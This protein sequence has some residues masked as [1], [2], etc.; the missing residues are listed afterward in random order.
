MPSLPNI[1][2]AA[3]TQATVQALRQKAASSLSSLT[4]QDL[5][6]AIPAGVTSKISSRLVDSVFTAG[7]QDKLDAVD[8]YGVKSSSLINTALQAAQSFGEDVLGMFRRSS[9]LLPNLANVLS[10]SS[11]GLNINGGNLTNRIINSLGGSTGVINGL[12]ASLKDTL[13]NTAGL[14]PNIYN[15]AVAVVGNITMSLE[16][17][18]L[19]DARGVFD[20]INR[21]TGQSGLAQFFDVGAE[22]NLISGL[23]GEL[24]QLGVPDAIDVLVQNAKQSKAAEAALLG[25]VMGAIQKSDMKTIQLM[26][27]KLGVGGVLAK[28]P[29][30]AYL[31]LTFYQ[32]PSGSKS[33]DYSGLLTTMVGIVS[34]L[35]PDW[36][37]YTRNGVTVDNLAPFTYASKDAL[38]LFKQSPTYAAAATIAP[39]YP[40]VDL[41]KY[42]KQTYP[43]MLVY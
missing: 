31:I 42:A 1:D 7:P 14:D 41:V 17:N 30:A 11:S 19:S 15:Q 35:K 10:L 34:T 40:A 4:S 21:V 29:N 9:G 5:T 23:T 36:N 32:I 3:Q 24:I 28:V 22:A 26:I 38:T 20:L 8:V 2:L 6:S 43:Y 13:V 18:Q 16:T 39:T 12:S 25:N 37:T 33:S 27:N